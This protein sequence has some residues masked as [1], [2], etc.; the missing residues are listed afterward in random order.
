MY[1]GPVRD[2]RW[3]SAAQATAHLGVK[4]QT[5]YAYVSRG[6]VRRERPPGSRTSRYSRAD[7]ERLAEHGRPRTREG[8]PEIAIDQ[9]V[10][11]LDPAGHLTYRGW[12]VTRAATSARY[13]EV[14]AWLWG[15]TIGPHEHWTADADGLALARAVQAA[16]PGDT[17]PP[18]RLRVVVAA[19]R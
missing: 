3:L 6:L 4:P 17:P 7:V 2:D 19:L 13:E 5:L 18:D 12:D 14:A 8:A 9:A 15:S 11:S 16:L 10:T 1:D